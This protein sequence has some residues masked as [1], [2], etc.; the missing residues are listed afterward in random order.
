MDRP[1]ITMLAWISVVIGGAACWLQL[2]IAALPDDEPPTIE[3]VAKLPGGSP[4]YV[5]GANRALAVLGG[6]LLSQLITLFLT[7]VLYLW[8]DQLGHR[9]AVARHPF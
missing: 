8:F 4:I 9:T 1:I 2:P 3:V 6:L 7:P 5:R